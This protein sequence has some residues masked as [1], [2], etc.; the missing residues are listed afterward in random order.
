MQ[1]IEDDISQL[2]E[3][4]RELSIRDPDLVARLVQNEQAL[5]QQ[6][7]TSQAGQFKFRPKRIITLAFQL[8]TSQCT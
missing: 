6:N 3:K 5:A 8:N 1:G 7:Q 4:V 2:L